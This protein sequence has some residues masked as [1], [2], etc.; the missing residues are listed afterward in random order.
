MTANGNISTAALRNVSPLKGFLAKA[1][2]QA[3]ADAEGGDIAA[4]RWLI[5]KGIWIAEYIAPGGGDVAMAW[6]VDLLAGW[7][8]EDER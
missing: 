7:R 6:C 2:R 8:S 4:L 1:L 3:R 5:T